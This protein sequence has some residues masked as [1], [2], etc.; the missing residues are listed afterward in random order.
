MATGTHFADDIDLGFKDLFLQF[1]MTDTDP[2]SAAENPAEYGQRGPAADSYR[3]LVPPVHQEPQQDG[4]SS[5][6]YLGHVDHRVHAVGNGS[7]ARGV[8]RGFETAEQGKNDEW[9]NQ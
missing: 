4:H 1:Q 7:I 6:E 2:Q 8:R 5:G 9:R 3:K